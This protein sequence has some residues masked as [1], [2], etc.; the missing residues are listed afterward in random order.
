[1]GT[2]SVGFHTNRIAELGFLSTSLMRMAENV[3]GRCRESIKT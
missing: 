3:L 2:V 1:M